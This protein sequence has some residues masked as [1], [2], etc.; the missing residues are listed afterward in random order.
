MLPD[1]AQGKGA[2]PLLHPDYLPAAFA[3]PLLEYF[4]HTYLQPEDPNPD[5]DPDPNPNQAWR[6]ATRR[7]R[8]RAGTWLGSGPRP[9]LGLGHLVATKLG[10]GHGLR[11]R[12][13][14]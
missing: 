7:C 8:P 2:K 5:P 4:L 13:W 9:G 14:G 6:E 1:G 3:K 10:L 11:V 12:L